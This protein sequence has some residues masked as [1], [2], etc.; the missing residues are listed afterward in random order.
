MKQRTLPNEAILQLSKKKIVPEL[1]RSKY[2]QSTVNN[3]LSYHRG[4]ARRTALCWL[5][6][7]QLMHN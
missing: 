7:C 2:Y 3:R 5:K 6:F 1:V 4:T